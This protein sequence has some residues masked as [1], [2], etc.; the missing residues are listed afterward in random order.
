M[1]TEIETSFGFLSDPSSD[2][3]QTMTLIKSFSFIT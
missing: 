3:E 1:I 2:P